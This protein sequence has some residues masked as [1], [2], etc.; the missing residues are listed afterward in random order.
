MID[1]VGRSQSPLDG[2]REWN[3]YF[4]EQDARAQNAW[5]QQELRRR[6]DEAN[7]YN[8]EGA[9]SDAQFQNDN[10]GLFDNGSTILAGLHPQ[11]APAVNGSTST[12]STAAPAG[13]SAANSST[14]RNPAEVMLG[15]PLRRGGD[16]GAQDPIG[17]QETT[18][19]PVTSFADLT[20]QESQA[21]GAYWRA[22]GT[23]VNGGFRYRTLSSQQMED[24]RNILRHVNL[25]V[26]N[27]GIVRTSRNISEDRLRSPWAATSQPSGGAPSARATIPP[28]SAA[29]PQESTGPVDLGAP[30]QLD[31]TPNTASNPGGLEPPNAYQMAND[32]SRGLRPTRE[33]QQLDVVIRDNL[34]RADLAAR[35]GDRAGAQAAFNQA[36][37]AQAS[38]TMQT[39]MV[40]YHAAASGSLD[41][42][43]TLLAQYNGHN[44]ADIRLQ[45]VNGT[46]GQR[47]TYNLQIRNNQGQWVTSS[48]QPQTRDEILSG[49]QNL[50]DAEGAA[51][52]TEANTA[53]MRE[54][55]QA[56][57]QIT[58]ATINERAAIIRAMTDLQMNR[59]DN[60]TRQQL[61]NGQGHVYLDPD[62]KGAWFEYST[63]DAQGRTVPHME[64]LQ[65]ENQRTPSTDGTRTTR[66]PTRTRVTGTVGTEGNN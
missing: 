45:P 33:M 29:T 13:T 54:R 20:P 46:S 6:Y 24:A 34:R 3:Q 18:A 52:R 62:N 48:E 1:F 27:G 2:M 55:I 32:T 37:Q 56:G 10:A 51:N 9:I 58:V 15:R 7:R 28:A 64:F 39:R 47:T 40:M 21:V 65:M 23:F 63:V 53:I 26:R 25:D 17:P 22:I 43:T 42:M 19:T 30:A 61:Q 59:L 12:A 14:Q 35:H 44:P 5:Q 66:V 50:I 16:N 41:A 49:L 31:D 60:A 38:L 57:A 8:R 36:M 4:S 11:D